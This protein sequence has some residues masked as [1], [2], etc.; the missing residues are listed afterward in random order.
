MWFP[1]MLPERMR[2]ACALLALTLPPGASA[3]AGEAAD[4]DVRRLIVENSIAAYRAHDQACA[5]P[6]DTTNGGSSC[7]GTSAYSGA[8]RG[9]LLCFRGDVTPAMI[10]AW[11]RAH[12]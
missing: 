9:T 8:A 12:P 10:L 6:Y 4:D 2:I 5:C 11:R 1:T 7:S 3:L